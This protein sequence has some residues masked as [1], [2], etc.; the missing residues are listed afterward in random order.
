ML[1]PA[2]SGPTGCT[3]SVRRRVNQLRRRS[4]DRDSLT[5]SAEM[6]LERRGCNGPRVARSAYTGCVGASRLRT[7]QRLLTLWV[8]VAVRRGSRV[9]EG[10][11]CRCH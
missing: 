1:P 9:A 6:R 3:G 11:R 7:N 5:W 2:V 8:E 4:A 10:M